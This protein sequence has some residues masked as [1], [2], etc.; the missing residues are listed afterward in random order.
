MYTILSIDGGGI[1]GIIPGQVMVT[2]EAKLAARVLQTPELAAHY[3]DAVRLSD[4]FDFFAGTSTGGILTT[5]Y[6]CPDSKNPGRPRFSAQDA[7]NLYL[8]QGDDIFDVSIWKKIASADGVGDEKHDAT[9]LERVLKRYLGNTKLSELLRPCLI[10]SYDIRRRRTHFFNQVDAETF[11]NSHDYLLRDV[12]RATSAAPTYFE[13]ALTCSLDE[14]T[15]PLID[16]GVFANNPALCAYSEVRN[17]NPKLKAADM[18]IVSLGTGSENESYSYNEARNWGSIAWVRPV[19]DI[20]M[21]GAAEVTDYHL[22]KMYSAV[23][24]ENQYIRFQP[25]DL[26]DADMAMDNA[27]PKNLRALLEV[28]KRTAIDCNDELDRLVDVLIS[29]K[30]VTLIATQVN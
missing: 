21:S 8:E 7:L 5:L 16:G 1:R 11:G 30:K 6:L 19:I 15:Y 10:T 26:G 13:T 29:N 22:T 3:T 24:R 23:K 20:M 2:L 12:C 25:A 9:Q 28:G 14:V 27:K 4:F 17:M 18:L